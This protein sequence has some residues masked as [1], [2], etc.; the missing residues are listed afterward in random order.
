MPGTHRPR[1]TYANVVA[2]IALVVALGGGTAAFAAAI[3][4][5]NGDVA[6]NVIS[7]HQPPAGIH[8]NVIGHTINGL[9]LADG[10]VTRGKIAKSAVVTGS[11]AGGSVT[12]DKIAPNAVVSGD[13]GAGAISGANLG[14]TAAFCTLTFVSLFDASSKCT[15]PDPTIHAFGRPQDGVICVKVPFTPTGGAV[16]MD[17]AAAGFP[18]GF[19]SV[20]AAEVL[21]AGCDPAT[22][23]NALV[24]TYAAAGGVLTAEEFHAIF[25]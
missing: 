16:T 6:K 20:D 21:A 12:S 7:G 8:P 10:A 24:T 11:L 19:M 15:G 14:T 23:Y 3:V 22:G 25:Y 4:H 18:V 1:L 17:S 13:V 5:S 2:T 9:D